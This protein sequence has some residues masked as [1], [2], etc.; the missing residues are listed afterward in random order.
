MTDI[1]THIYNAC[2]P[3]RP[4]SAEYYVR[5]AIKIAQRGT[6]AP[7]ENGRR[8]LE[9]IV[10][11]RAG[12][13]PL[14]RIIEP[15]ALDFLITYSGGN[16]PDFLR[17]IQGAI[18]NTD[19]P[20]ITRKA[21]RRALKWTIDIMAGSVRA[22]WWPKLAALHLS[23]NQSI[24]SMDQD[25]PDMLEMRFILEYLDGDDEGDALVADAPWYAVHP[26]LRELPQFTSAV[27]ELSGRSVA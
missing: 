13:V 16:V 11:E 19:E 10:R 7:F 20:P 4:A 15:D 24:D 27:N 25:M 1:L 18:E 2:D 9:E 17:F 6:Y 26:I 8:R 23:S 3:L 5:P 12:D 22:A 21:A 14:D